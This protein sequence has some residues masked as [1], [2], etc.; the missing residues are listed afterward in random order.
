LST[1]W[2]V[3]VLSDR[4]ATAE[5]IPFDQGTLRDLRE[6]AVTSEFLA[7]VP[8][9]KLL[10]LSPED[11]QKY[12]DHPKLAIRTPH[13]NSAKEPYVLRD[14]VVC[15]PCP[16]SRTR[17]TLP[18]CAASIPALLT[19]TAGWVELLSFCHYER[20]AQQVLVTLGACHCL[21]F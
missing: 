6:R 20:H 4:I 1:A 13:I 10:T 12:I 14:S 17:T 19:Q 15:S 9:T 5:D 21:C 3:L 2:L 11:R 8:V 16:R 18:A 7:T